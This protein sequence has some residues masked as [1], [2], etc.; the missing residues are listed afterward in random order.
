MVERYCAFIS[1]SHADATFA[2]WLHSRLQT[3]RFPKQVTQSETPDGQL[4]KKLLPVFLDREELP[5]ATSLTAEVKAALERS[6]ALVVI[7]SPNAAASQWVNREIEVFRELHP[8]R[9]ILLALASGEPKKAFPPALSKLD[10]TAEPLA[11]DFR[12]NSDGRRLGLLK[13]IAGLAHVPLTEL[14][15]RDAQRKL[16][17]VMAVTALASVVMVAMAIM[18]Y[19]AI[20]ARETAE[21]QRA[22][23][24]GLVDFMVTDLRG[25]LTEV[26]RIDLMSS[27]NQR[28]Q[29]Y[30]QRQGDAAR[31]ANDSRDLRAL[32]LMRLGQDDQALGD[33][34]AAEA[35][36]RDSLAETQALLED[37]PGDPY[38]MFRHAEGQ[39]R[40]ALLAFERGEYSDALMVWEPVLE[41]LESSADWGNEREEWVRLAAY[42]QGNIC[43]AQVSRDRA[44]LSDFSACRN[45]VDR[46]LELIE[47]VDRRL[48]TV[49]EERDDGLY[50]L[51]YHNL[52][53]AMASLRAGE[54]DI[55]ETAQ[56]RYLQIAEQLVADDPQDML[57]RELSME[58]HV[59]HAALLRSIGQEEAANSYFER[60]RATNALLIERDPANARWREYRRQVFE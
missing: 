43:A 41:L 30:Y 13:L 15:Q 36:Y 47:M 32:S 59:R 45:A 26:G 31:L 34:D 42:A 19:V 55:S 46:N 50:D 27:V 28:V 49:S 18:T 20:Q 25:K 40:I 14:L 11:A 51:A 29:Q 37:G 57:R 58:I 38:R 8:G 23:A 35:H 6:D 60:A 52:W 12:A 17:R 56:Q 16:R 24:E 53:L 22:E 33:F 1:Y 44:P 39:N 48:N 2:K 54:P 7:C 5:A 3:Y 21:Q 9:P 10:K 4:N